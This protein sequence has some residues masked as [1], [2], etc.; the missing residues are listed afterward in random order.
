MSDDTDPSQLDIASRSA[1]EAGLLARRRMRQSSNEPDVASHSGQ[2]ALS[3]AQKS[4]WFSQLLAPSSPKYNI[5]LAERIEGSLDAD[6]LSRAFDNLVAR[7][8]VLRLRFEHSG[9]GPRARISDEAPRLS[10]ADL[11]AT[12]AMDRDDKAQSLVDAEGEIPI[13]ISREPCVRASL[14]RFAEDDSL[15]IIVVHHIASDEWSTRTLR[16]DLGELYR[17]HLLNVPPKLG[18]LKFQ[19]A[20]AAAYLEA[21]QKSQ[22]HKEVLQRWA[23]QLE[24]ARPDDGLPRSQVSKAKTG[25]AF[26]VVLRMPS[27]VVAEFDRVGSDGGATPY[28]TMLA[29]CL[30]FLHARTGRDDLAIA[31]Q[32]AGRSRPEMAK[33]IGPFTN[34]AVIRSQIGPDSS[35]LDVL[36]SVRKQILDALTHQDTRYEALIKH[37]RMPRSV[38]AA[39][40]ACI[41]FTHRQT[42]GKLELAD[43]LSSLA[44]RPRRKETKNNLWISVID[45]EDGRDI[46][47][48]YDS[49][50]YTRDDMQS[51][52]GE[53]DAIVRKIALVP[54]VSV[55]ELCALVEPSCSSQI[56]GECPQDSQVDASTYDQPVASSDLELVSR[57]WAD[58]LGT[59]PSHPDVSFFD[60]GG[61]SLLMMRLVNRLEEAASVTISLSEAFH[62]STAG[63]LAACVSKQRKTTVQSDECDRLIE[64]LVKDGARDAERPRFFLVSGGGGHVAPFARVA[65]RMGDRWQGLGILDP[66]IFDDEPA[67][68]TIEDLARRMAHAL[69]SA[70]ADGPWILAGYSAGGRAVYEIARQLRAEGGIAG[71]VILDAGISREDLRGETFRLLRKV[72]RAGRVGI[73]SISD[74]IAESRA[75]G[76]MTVDLQGRRF[77]KISDHQHGRLLRYK[78]TASD[79]PVVLIRA[80][81]SK[82]AR[83]SAD[84]GWRRVAHFLGVVDTPGDHW[85]CFKDEN[86]GPFSDAFARGLQMMSEQL[87]MEISE[88]GSEP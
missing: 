77:R 35:F 79:T 27:D 41:M 30:C 33:L 21:R 71:C 19:Y 15:L 80:T 10:I 67:I 82:R 40:F 52:I 22:S 37:M 46:R 38:D 75:H 50:I 29:A 51:A 84:Y 56:D 57:L 81:E 2:M 5:V 32:I 47:L 3:A 68:G 53:L 61:D 6:C 45:V 88:R 16:E 73:R 42:F 1:L 65:A 62:A 44:Y 58:V 64:P 8:D 17:A 85:N 14:H 87:A 76:K 31:T 26:E 54:H 9:E 34:T 36:E 11:R 86:S 59:D 72:K 24:G 49:G 28:M 12:P 48:V 7:H 25:A 55:A 23:E 83:R 13:D 39:P 4:I 74:R 43:G 60:A 18:P 69:K 63:M 20:D 78:P 70:D 66:M